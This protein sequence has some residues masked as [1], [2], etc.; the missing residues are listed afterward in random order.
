MNNSVDIVV[1]SLTRATGRRES[2]SSQFTRLGLPFSFYDAIDG[3]EGHDLF[4][5]YDAAKARRIGELHL[6]QGHKG[7]FASHYLVWQ[8]CVS[9]NHPMIVL[10]D[11]ASIFE[12]PF[13]AFLST[14]PDLPEYF[15]CVRLFA[16][17]S[18]NTSFVP[19]YKDDN[20]AIGKFTRGHKSATGYYL[21]PAAAKKFLRYCESWVEPV[22]IEMDQFWSNGVECFGVLEACVTHN[23]EFV[24]AID[25][26]VD[27][28]KERRGLMRWR[29]RWYLA[30]GKVRR[31]FHNLGFRLMMLAKS[32]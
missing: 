31:G 18:R 30:K 25:F 14:I 21:T 3:K 24:S 13:R 22:D 2:I 6:S 9:K 16:S 20:V 1:I 17:K 27:T 15:E 4:R 7:C 5:K 10:E 12:G 11:D 26:G 8:S 32:F 28:R 23:P 19:T 29:W